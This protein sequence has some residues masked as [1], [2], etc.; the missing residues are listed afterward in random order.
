MKAT[1]V[2]L[3]A[4]IEVNVVGQLTDDPNVLRNLAYRQASKQYT[5]EG[6]IVATSDPNKV[7]ELKEKMMNRGIEIHAGKAPE[8]VEV[9][10]TKESTIIT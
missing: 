10:E 6:N 1:F 4:V 5:D 3:P 2:F 7:T 9:E 8:K